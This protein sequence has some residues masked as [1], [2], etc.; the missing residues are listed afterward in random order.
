MT[1]SKIQW[2]GR[3]DWNPIRGCTR[4]SPGCGGPGPHGGCYAE[5]I[6]ARFSDPGQA[7]HSFAERGKSGPHWTGHVELIEDRVTL[8]LHWRKPAM[9]FPSSMSDIFHE[10][11]PD[12][13]IDRLFAVM[14]LTPWHTYQP[15][16]KRTDRM[17]EYFAADPR[18][19]IY[20]AAEKISE[21]HS[22][23]RST[24]TGEWPLRNV[25]LGFSAENQEYLAER[26]LF[27]G[28][29]AEQ[30]WL[31]WCSAEPLL[32]PLDLM[33]VETVPDRPQ[34]KLSWLVVGGESGPRSRPF[35]AD[36]AAAI[37][38]QCGAAGVPCFVKQLGANPWFGARHYGPASEKYIHDK[39]GGDWSEWPASLRVREMPA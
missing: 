20:D 32:G 30:G 6:A 36:W 25:W 9:I 34:R 17:R 39:K 14:V 21:A 13:A 38:E 10:K 15:L 3:S 29:L 26:W 28:D 16:T 7:F 1:A 11:L 4:V 18:A 19:R 5:A 12:S 22:G 2:T 27:A 33:C 23:H 24:G 31:V 37:I 35:N 8:P